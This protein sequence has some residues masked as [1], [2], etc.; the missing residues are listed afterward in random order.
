MGSIPI[1]AAISRW[2]LFRLVDQLR[3]T[4]FARK[5]AQRFRVIRVIR[6]VLP[7][8]NMR[9]KRHLKKLR[10]TPSA[11]RYVSSMKRHHFEIAAEIRITSKVHR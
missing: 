11:D 4:L 3:T 7:T 2:Q 9:D 5:L 6:V 1:R 8:L 10:F